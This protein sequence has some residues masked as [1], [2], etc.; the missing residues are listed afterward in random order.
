MSFYS[1]RKD[2]SFRLGRQ[3]RNKKKAKLGSCV[4]M[5]SFGYKICTL[6]LSPFI[7]VIRDGG[8]TYSGN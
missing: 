6:K 4:Y 5:S 1:Q 2:V 7:I 8:S 3:K